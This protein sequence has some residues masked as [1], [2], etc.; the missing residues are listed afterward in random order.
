VKILITGGSG[1]IG[2]ASKEVLPDAIYVSSKDCDLRD[3][4]STQKLYK[5]H[6]P[7]QVIHLAAKVGGIAANSNY[8]ADFY[9]E[10]MRINTNVLQ[11]AHLSGVKKV[12]SMLSTCIYPD[13]AKYPLTE[14]QIHRGPPHYSNYAYAY[15]KRMLDIQSQA[16]RDQYGCNFITAVPNNLYGE[17]DN[18]HLE[19]SHL[20][21]AIIRKVYEAKQNKTDVTLWGSGAPL[22]EFTYSKD[23]ARIVVL[24]LEEYDGRYPINVGN[25][26]E[27]SVKQVAKTISEILDFKGEILWDTSRPSG[28]FRKPSDNSKFI[29]LGWRPEDYTPLRIGLESMCQW[30]LENYPNVR[31]VK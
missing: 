19:N 8:L 28:Q 6:K 29:E 12:V 13:K 25:T 10:N 21:P 20:I 11:G 18:F 7:D 24:L 30:F 31:G 9:T 5:R 26:A 16:Y 22:R 14:S 1:M 3:A 2:Q 4:E 27:Y 15:A 23:L 17:Y